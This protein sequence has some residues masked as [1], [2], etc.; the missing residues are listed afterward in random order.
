MSEGANLGSGLENLSNALRF[1]GG[2]RESEDAARRALG[3]A[4]ERKDRFHGAISLYWLGLTLAAT[5]EVEASELALRRSLRIRIE[6]G[7]P[8]GEGLVSAYLAQRAIWFGEY[9]EALSFADHAWERAHVRRLERDLIRASR[10]QG[11]AALGLD[12][13]DMADKRLHHALTRARAVNL[14]EEELPTLTALS[15]LRRR[16]GNEKAASE[17]LDDVWEHAE[18]GPYPL[19]HADALNVLAQIERDAGNTDKAIGAATKAYQLAWCD[20]PPYAY[21]GGLIRAQKHL[22][23]LGAPLPDM[24][25]FDES[26]FEPMPEVEIDPDDEFHVGEGEES[27]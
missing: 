5:G 22:E 25:P 3:I 12:D 8:Q 4:R 18:R 21:H 14:V 17:F 6:Q 9:A 10:R 1:T 23:E 13:L 7:N 20:G 27:S 2:L 24:P 26:K 15:E 16:Q 19:Y 11:E